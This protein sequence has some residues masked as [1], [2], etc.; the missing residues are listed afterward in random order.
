[1][2]DP[3]KDFD[4]QVEQAA[5]LISDG[6]K[7]NLDPKLVAATINEV[8]R[9]MFGFK[10]IGHFRPTKISEVKWFMPMN[11]SSGWPWFMKT[12]K[13][14]S[15]VVSEA[16]K[17]YDCPNGPDL[18]WSNA[19]VTIGT[20]AQVRRKV[21]DGIVKFVVKYRLIFVVPKVV[22]VYEYLFAAVLITAAKWNQYK[23]VYSIGSNYLHLKSFW[24]GAKNY[25]FQ[26]MLDYSGFDQ[27]VCSTFISLF[28]HFVRRSFSLNHKE[29]KILDALERYHLTAKVWIGPDRFINRT[30]GVLSG[31]AFTNIMD[32]FVN[33]FMIVYFLLDHGIKVDFDQLRVMG[34]DVWLALNKHFPL[35]YLQSYFYKTFGMII[36]SD[37]SGY[38]VQGGKPVY[39]LGAWIDDKK[40]YIDEDLCLAQL[41]VSERY[42]DV[43]VMSKEERV[44]SKF[45]SILSK[46]TD[47]VYVWNKHVHYIASLIG[48][49]WIPKNVFVL[50]WDVISQQNI[51]D[52]RYI[53]SVQDMLS[54]FWMHQ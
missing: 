37:K 9:L 18:Q 45:C 26:Y 24:I 14:F 19:P 15:T 44:F 2:G 52:K 38:Y 3:V 46:F 40:R 36:N 51:Y 35:E 43:S 30:G 21:I 27:H 54:S 23:S 17:L 8:S 6:R 12:S 42:I 13:V 10:V 32:S 20:R 39:Y 7:L 5:K 41:I 4:K 1:M 22:M 25:K 31:S 53:A 34:D 16:Q 11:A 28:F 33:T 48:T 49:K 50:G 29:S 47:G